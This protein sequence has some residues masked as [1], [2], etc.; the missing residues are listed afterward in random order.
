MRQSV[1][2]LLPALQRVQ[3]ATTR[4]QRHDA[5]GV[6]YSLALPLLTH[7]CGAL[8]RRYAPMHWQ[9]AEDLA[10]DTLLPLVLVPHRS[11]A[12]RAATSDGVLSWL[13]G[14]AYRQ[15]RSTREARACRSEG[16]RVVP[17]PAGVTDHVAWAPAQRATHATPA[18]RR[19]YAHAIRRLHPLDQRVWIMHVEQ[20][21]PVAEIA[22]D[23][24]Q[25]ANAVRRRLQRIALELRVP[26]WAYAPADFP[27]SLARTAVPPCERR[28]R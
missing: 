27:I 25:T 22:R 13:R 11:R 26:L 4:T 12:C 9:S 20:E 16:I 5:V 7:R 17:M 3:Q 28:A 18:F 10:G 15:L 14:A 23:L 6:F 19:D 2:P 24:G 21:I 1:A 8:L